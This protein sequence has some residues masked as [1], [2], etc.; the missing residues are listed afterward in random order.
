MLITTGRLSKERTVRNM[1]KH[2]IIIGGGLGGLA[3]AVRLGRTCRV[4][5]LEKLPRVGGKL[6]LWEASHPTRQNDR[7][8]RFD[9]GPSLLTMPFVFMDLYAAAGEDVRDHLSITRLDPVSRFAWADGSSFSLFDDDFALHQELA[10]FAP[11]DREGWMRFLERGR[12]IWELGEPFLTHAP[13]QLMR[14]D[15]WRAIGMITVPFRIGMFSR[16]S[17]TIDRNVKHP[18]L[19]DILYQYATYSGASP[20]HAPGTLAVIP[21]VEHYFGGWHIDGG[22]YQLAKSLEGIARKNDVELRM[23]TSVAE[24]LVEAGVAVG[25]RLTD[26]TELRADAVIANS[27]VVYTYRNLIAPQHRK[28]YS[29]I[30]LDR[31]DPGG[32][33]M[34]LMLGIEGTYPQLAHHTK[35][36]PDNYRDELAAMFE[37]RAIPDD[38]CIYVCAPTR[39]DP[40]LAPEGCEQLFVLV[41][42]PSIRGNSIDWTIEAPRYRD[43]IVRTLETRFGLTELGKRIVVEKIHTPVDL[44]DL[45][46]ANAGSIY[47]IA[48]N[49]LRT[50]FLRPPNRD[51]QIKRLYHAGGA[52]H[53]GGGLPLVALSGKIVSELVAADLGIQDRA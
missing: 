5:L 10:R 7:P 11:D 51:Q 42:A 32:S 46:N 33:G 26:G 34:I 4:T 38:P 22:M 1:K 36:M 29:D 24:I 21:W 14:F 45:Y 44:K 41:S 39:T 8:F 47:G 52:T 30:A 25:V 2:V 49:S 35:F 16:L 48:S 53:P 37:S 50:A 13:E 40:T 17:K 9:T 3:A 43:R 23:G 18:R 31:F 20:F 12:K 15:D 19:R 6:N 27:D 28:R